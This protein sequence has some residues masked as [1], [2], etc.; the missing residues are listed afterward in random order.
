MNIKS[1]VAAAV[2]AAASISTVQAAQFV[3]GYDIANARTSGYGGWSHTYSGAITSAGGGL[4]NYTGGNG[5]LNDGIVSANESS[6]Q[7]FQLTDNTSI[8]LHLNSPTFLSELNIFGASGNNG[9][10]IPGTLIGATLSFGGISQVLSST[11]WGPACAAALCNDRFSFAGT[12][13]ASIATNFITL[14]N[15]QVAPGAWSTYFNASEI[16]I[17]GVAAVSPVPEP[18]TYAMLLAGLG[19]MGGMARRRKQ[20]LATA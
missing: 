1:L 13:L 17:S 19:L 14:S 10:S 18:E 9:N 16:S 11:A 3:T 7:L 5:T 8:T 12:S 6:N 20:K 4:S 2:I 15:F